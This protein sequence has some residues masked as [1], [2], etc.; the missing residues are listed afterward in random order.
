VRCEA[1][2]R[3]PIR[4]GDRLT[5]RI[6]AVEVGRSGFT[7]SWKFSL[8]TTLAMSVRVKRVAIDRRAGES[9]DLP[10]TFRAWLEETRSRV[11]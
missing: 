10:E 11:G 4:C 9:I 2:Y 5:V 8:E 7:L 3:M 1:D 6:D